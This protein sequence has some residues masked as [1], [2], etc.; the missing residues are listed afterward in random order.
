MRPN[1]SRIAVGGSKQGSPTRR[2][3]A[4]ARP[5]SQ[6]GDHAIECAFHTPFLSAPSSVSRQVLMSSAKRP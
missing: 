5:P 1:L 3:T 4:F 2:S 6:R